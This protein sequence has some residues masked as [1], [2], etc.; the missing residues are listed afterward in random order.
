M[1]SGH[2][3]ADFYA[4]NAESADG[5]NVDFKDFRGKVLLISNISLN[6]GTTVQLRDLEQLHNLYSE[7]GLV[8]LGFPS[9]DFSKKEPGSSQ[10]I[11]R[12]CKTRYGVNFPL[13][14]LQPVIGP[15][16]QPV[17]EYLTERV[18]YEMRGEVGFNFEKFL[19]A[20]DGTVRQRYGPFTNA[21]SSQLKL[22]IE[23]LLKE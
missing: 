23:E 4:L 16:K 9:D 19:I 5:K 8:V 7:Q 13:F 18:P 3:P 22:D 11:K 17:F 20:K 12:V 14:A 1:R 15:K 6:C 10:E 2:A 21:M